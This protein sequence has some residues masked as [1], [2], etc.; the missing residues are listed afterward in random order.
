[1][2]E[3]EE[4]EPPVK[5]REKSAHLHE[6]LQSVQGSSAGSGNGPCP[7]SGHQ[8]P[9]P[10]PRLPLFHRELIR[11]CQVLANIEDLWGRQA[12]TSVLLR[13]PW[14]SCQ[15]SGDS[16]CLPRFQV[17]TLMVRME[18]A[19]NS[20]ELFPLAQTVAAALDFVNHLDEERAS[21]SCWVALLQVAL[22][23]SGKDCRG[24]PQGSGKMNRNLAT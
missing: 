20:L 24:G 8:V 19:E 15:S 10:H 11:D 9:P 23:S 6:H 2:R 18:G 12:E 14:P 3:G 16:H 1:M 7:T 21:Q 5:H 13:T 4:V 22:T 17:A